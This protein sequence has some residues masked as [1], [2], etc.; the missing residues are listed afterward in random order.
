MTEPK[1]IRTFTMLLKAILTKVRQP[2]VRHSLL[3][4]IAF[5][6][7]VISQQILLL[8]ALAAAL[9]PSLSASLFIFISIFSIATNTLGNELGI[10]Q[11]LLAKGNISKDV[12]Q[13][14]RIPL[15]ITNVA[16]FC[17][18]FIAMLLVD[19]EVAGA[20]LFALAAVMANTRLYFIGRLRALNRFDSI[21][22]Q[23]AAYL[24]GA[25]VG[26]WIF[27]ETSLLWA[28]FVIAELVALIIVGIKIN[29]VK[30][31]LESSDNLS[32]SVL[33]RSFK[34]MSTMA[35][36][37]NLI[38]YSDRVLILPIIG[39][40]AT[41]TYY[42][43]S[44]M[45]RIVALIANPLNTVFFTG[46]YSKNIVNARE[47]IRKSLRVSALLALIV[48]LISL[49]TTYF[50]TNILYPQFSDSVV[51]IIPALAIMCGFDTSSSIL[52][53]VL[54]KFEEANRV[55]RLYTVFFFSFIALCLTGGIMVGLVGFVY[56]AAISRVV[57]FCVLSWSLVMK[58]RNLS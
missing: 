28:P 23:S 18:I 48:T 3:N 6:V 21:L 46:L 32:M 41:N 51:N 56:A 22:S 27:N 45:S 38:A 58:V 55:S 4:T 42:A 47:F 35:L 12:V 50:A 14:F 26:L 9:S 31:R 7:Y 49:P 17:I 33:L 30:A 39:V 24:A 8:P 34:S 15:I 43:G 57:L 20:C 19:I 44:T 25:L 11:Q 54:L 13:K 10:T 2:V 37:N 16:V 40:A 53:I 1:H 29:Q 36:I 5:G 52:R